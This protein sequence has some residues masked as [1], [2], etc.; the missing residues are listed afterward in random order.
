[1][2]FLEAGLVKP[3]HQHASGPRFGSNLVG[4]P[5]IERAPPIDACEPRRVYH[6]FVVGVSRGDDPTRTYDTAKLDERGD[7][8]CQMLQD[9]VRVCRV[10]AVIGKRESIGIGDFEAQVVDASSGRRLLGSP[11]DALRVVDPGHESGRDESRDVDSDATGA[12]SQIEHGHALAEVRSKVRRTVR[13]RSPG[14]VEY[15]S[16]MVPVPVQLAAF[17]T[18]H[19]LCVARDDFQVER[20][21]DAPDTLGDRSSRSRTRSTRR[22]QGNAS[23][24]ELFSRSALP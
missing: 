12:A 19:P 5:A 14:V 18:R 8:V 22:I 11:D 3:L 13:D 15:D 24:W 6:R 16:K 1:M 21:R 2:D 20:Q 10:E 23:E 4:D 9:L 7:R 17:V